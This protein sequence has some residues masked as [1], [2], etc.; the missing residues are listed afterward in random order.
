MIPHAPPARQH[1]AHLLA[2]HVMESIVRRASD[3]PL[4]TEMP[5]DRLDVTGHAVLCKNRNGEAMQLDERF[6]ERD[7]INPTLAV[8]PWADRNLA[9]HAGE[10]IAKH[11]ARREPRRQL[12]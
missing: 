1:L 3:L 12:S 4:D 5:N 8:E 6:V 7:R 2:G 10:F 11:A 9:G